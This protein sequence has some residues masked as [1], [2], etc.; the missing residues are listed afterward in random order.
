MV[1]FILEAPVGVSDRYK[2]LG[3]KGDLLFLGAL[4]AI[5]C[6]LEVREEACVCISALKN[7]RKGHGKSRTKEEAEGWDERGRTE[8]GARRKWG[9]D[10]RGGEEGRT[11]GRA[12]ENENQKLKAE[13][14]NLKQRKCEQQEPQGRRMPGGSRK[15]SVTMDRPKEHRSESEGS[16]AR[17][18]GG[19]S[20][21]GVCRGA[22]GPGRSTSGA[23]PECTGVHRRAAG[24]CRRTAKARLCMR[25]KPKM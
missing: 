20:T 16:R 24:A 19:R 1:G 6:G 23:P 9:A 14:T 15:G 12:G 2:G 21:S 13:G 3:R 17:P 4:R 18:E 5:P 8:A 22:A 10:G 25:Q 11:K 7:G